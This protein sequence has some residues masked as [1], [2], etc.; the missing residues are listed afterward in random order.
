[1]KKNI[2][3]F[4]LFF[5]LM[6]ISSASL[7][8]MG[9]NVVFASEAEAEQ[10]EQQVD[11]P[12]Y[13][14]PDNPED[15][16]EYMPRDY[17]EPDDVKADA[18]V[19]GSLRNNL[20]LIT[21]KGEENP[22]EQYASLYNNQ[23]QYDLINQYFNTGKYSLKDYYN[24]VSNGQ[25]DLDTEVFTQND[26]GKTL[27]IIT[28]EDTREHF[29]PYYY[30]DNGAAKWVKNTVGYFE[31]VLVQS[32][33]PVYSA[34]S[35]AFYNSKI[36]ANVYKDTAA[37]PTDTSTSDGVTSYTTAQKLADQRS[38]YYLLSSPMANYREYVLIC[39]AFEKIQSKIDLENQDYNNDNYVD[40]LSISF[41]K[42]KTKNIR[43]GWSDLLWPHKWSIA[44]CASNSSSVTVA[45]LRKV[46]YTSREA[47]RIVEYGK[48]RPKLSNGK[49]FS[50]YFV[51]D[52]DF[53]STDLTTKAGWNKMIE[54]T[55][56]QIHETGHML[57]LP[58]L[59]VYN[60]GANDS[61]FVGSWSQMCYNPRYPSAPSLMTSHERYKMGWLNDDNVKEIK[62]NGKYTLDVTKGYEGDNIVGF[63]IQHPT[64][65]ANKRIFLEYRNLYASKYD[66]AAGGESGLL[67]Y[68]VNK[69]RN[70][71]AYAPPYEIYIFR[72]SGGNV[73]QAPIQAGQ[74]FG[75]A[76]LSETSNILFFM[77]SSNNIVNS[78]IVVTVDSMDDYTLTFTIEWAE[79][80]STIYSLADFGGNRKLYNKLKSQSLTEDLT[81]ESFVGATS[82]D[83]SLCDVEDMSF[84]EKFNLST[85]NYL[86]LA[87]NYITELSYTQLIRNMKAV[88][89]NGNMLTLSRI[90]ST[91]LNAENY[92]FGIQFKTKERVFANKDVE[93][94]YLK[95]ETDIA[96]DA[97]NSNSELTVGSITRHYLTFPN[98]YTITTTFTEG[99]FETCEIA[100]LSVG[101]IT[102]KYDSV[103]N[104]YGLWQGDSVSTFLNDVIT[105]ECISR[106]RVEFE[107][108]LPDTNVV[109]N[110][111]TLISVLDIETGEEICSVLVHYIVRDD[112][113]PEVEFIGGQS[114]Y[115][116]V[117]DTFVEYGIN[118]REWGTLVPYTQV[119]S[120]NGENNTY[121]VI[122]KNKL[123]NI[124]VKEIDMSVAG[125]YIAQYRLID[126]FGRGF[127][128]YERRIR[129]LDNI[130]DML[131]IDA[132]IYQKLMEITE[133]E[134]LLSTSL[135]NYDKLDLSNLGANT[136]Q[137][138]EQFEYK[139]DVIIDFSGNNFSDTSHAQTLITTRTNIQYIY[140]LNNN[141][142]HDDILGISAYRSKSVYGFQKV[143][144]FYV[145]TQEGQKSEIPFYDDLPSQ[146]N[147]VISKNYTKNNHHVCLE[148][149]GETV[150]SV[151]NE[152]AETICEYTTTNIAIL[153]LQTTFTKEYSEVFAPNYNEIFSVK[154]V[155][156]TELTVTNNFSD[157]ELNKLGERKAVITIKK[158]SDLL[159]EV[160]VV[161]NVVDTQQPTLT[162]VGDTKLYLGSAKEYYDRYANN[163]CTA[164][165]GY[166][167]EI[168][169]VEKNEPVI[170]GYGEYVVT[171]KA[172]DSSGNESVLERFVYIGTLTF[173]YSTIDA[174]YNE[175]FK[176]PYETIT[177]KKEDFNVKYKL[178]NELIYTNYN[179]SVGIKF[180]QYGDIFIAVQFTHKYNAALV[181][182]FDVKVY[183]QDTAAPSIFLFG[184]YNYEIYAGQKFDEPGYKITDNSVKEELTPDKKYVAGI[185]LVIEYYKVGASGS[186]TSASKL[187]TSSVGQY[188]IKYIAT[189]NYGNSKTDE[190]ML[191][192]KY[193]PIDNVLINTLNLQSR[194]QQGKEVEISIFT[195]SEYITNPN[196]IVS[197]YINGQKVKTVTELETTLKFEDVGQFEVYAIVVDE[198]GTSVISDRYEFDIYKPSAAEPFVVIAGLA[199]AA[200]VVGVFAIILIKRYRNRNFY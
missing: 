138:M 3:L 147:V 23:S 28:L 65:Y 8:F 124:E 156:R 172:K 63:Y 120:I 132:K 148:E 24:T 115:F 39:E 6:A 101:R 91:N 162:L 40:C 102:T 141:F 127:D 25:L 36:I 71:N 67:M 41:F 143:K 195:D 27:Q 4:I 35:T 161:F 57:G 47:E 110:N 83:V 10:I 121:E 168:T 145:V 191:T 186:V 137:G 106:W 60:N 49:T 86:N 181:Y 184:G 112:S 109:G 196:P 31:Y 159:A 64:L 144:S 200:I 176:F 13:V 7:L 94:T 171:Y 15:Y 136:L 119:E 108:T 125:E 48:K 79:F 75:S 113:A 55:S 129:V 19:V 82:L 14:D 174:N 150:I 66:G 165:D 72:P 84:L 153:P 149:Y 58:D 17:A 70:G 81:N 61:S 100:E 88:I 98:E 93:I 123:T 117:G 175:Y 190:R 135:L 169:S 85:I 134:V 2:K 103:Q 11:G 73:R 42:T 164:Y 114:I 62:S 33:T 107:G 151:Y 122:Y 74:T 46:G 29:L 20:F 77:D 140:L 142:N 178:K 16:E 1:M 167:G 105:L 130:I 78:G 133:E 89:F 192:I 38:D 154:G 87:G 30:Y 34:T 21:F 12:D 128:S 45:N 166:D 43:I 131:S 163:V 69:A 59:Y 95:K 32:S 197:W 173:A 180:T 44:G 97:I 155:E 146:L 26:D 157:A 177:F 187:D 96:I 193:Y 56:T 37:M 182:N 111:T 53:V 189:D 76:N 18:N 118:V 116:A 139:Q 194:Y 183:I 152:Y 68:Y 198:Y 170:N 80:T 158:Q 51:A 50:T 9:Q 160:E 92:N 99:G 185:N 188:L 104:A 54:S 179:D 126:S 52:F 22:F 5:A 90:S 199:L